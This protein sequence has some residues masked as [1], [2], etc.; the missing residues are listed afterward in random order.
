MP[1]LAGRVAIGADDRVRQCGRGDRGVQARMLDRDADDR[2]GRGA[3][4]GCYMKWAS[5]DVLDLDGV[6]EVSTG[7]N[8]VLVLPL[9]GSCSVRSDGETLELTGRASVFD[10][11]TDFAYLP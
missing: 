5:L 6:R 1:R 8:E 2:R 4:G 11:T 7:S 3:T 10:G 9:A